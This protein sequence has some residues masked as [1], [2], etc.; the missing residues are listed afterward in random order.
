M[1][2]RI[3]P[4]N[5]IAQRTKETMNNL[6]VG[7]IWCNFGVITLLHPD[8]IRC[9]GVIT[10]EGYTITPKSY[11]SKGYLTSCQGLETK[12]DL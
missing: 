7:V 2:L 8:N 11:T 4:M 12:N 9:N 6:L 3:V 5:T 10:L 1:S